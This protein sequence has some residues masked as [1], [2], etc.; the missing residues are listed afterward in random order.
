MK[1]DNC[2]EFGS[3]MTIFCG[4]LKLKLYFQRKRKISLQTHLRLGRPNLIFIHYLICCNCISTTLKSSISLDFS[5]NKVF[6]YISFGNKTEVSVEILMFGSGLLILVYHTPKILNFK[7]HLT[8]KD[9]L[10]CSL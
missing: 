3:G 10:T 2:L 5:E 8:P 9:F 6:F 1:V 7:A 4:F